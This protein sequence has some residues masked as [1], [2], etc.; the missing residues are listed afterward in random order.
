MSDPAAVSLLAMES[1]ENI[2]IARHVKTS[3]ML[4]VL[5]FGVFFSLPKPTASTRVP[6]GATHSPVSKEVIPR[7]R[8]CAKPSN[9]I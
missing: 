1:I 2:I 4:L 7:V 3:K 9:V 8:P 6:M 5:E